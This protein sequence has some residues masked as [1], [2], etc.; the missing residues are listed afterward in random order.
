MRQK[1]PENNQIRII[2][3]ESEHIPLILPLFDAYRQ[4][5]QQSTDIE[6]AQAFLTE[7][8]KEGSSVIFLSMIDE[9]D[10][11]NIA[12]GFTQ[13]YPTFSSV[14]MKRLWILNDLFVVPEVRQQGVGKALLEHARAFASTTQ[15]KGLT[16]KTAINNYP[17]QALYES[18]GW[19]RDESFV[20]YDLLVM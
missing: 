16:L 18:L 8:F 17:A 11:G 7:R 20:S 2:K 19:Q 1:T 12:C 10:N 4:F 15:A 3:A 14:S 9:K 6:G 13:L 5:Y